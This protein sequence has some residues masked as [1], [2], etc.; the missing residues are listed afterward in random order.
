MGWLLADLLGGVVHWW[1]DRVGR[2]RLPWLVKHV[3]EPNLRHHADPMAFTETGF[4]TRNGTTMFA[5]SIAGLAWLVL[6]GPSAVLFF[7]YLGGALQNEV[8]YL[9]HKRPAGW[10]AVFQQIGI[11][12]SVPGH[13]KHHLPPQNKNY[14]VLTD[15]C[16]P[17]LEH[18]DVWNRLERR[19]N[20]NEVTPQ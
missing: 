15:W 16:N 1:E 19:L 11:I 18:L 3:F 10:L 12:Q 17:V 9:T 4:W 2:P 8:H 13:A 6:F 14:C 5:A 20:I 7:A